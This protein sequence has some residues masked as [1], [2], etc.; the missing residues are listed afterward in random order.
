MFKNTSIKA[1]LTLVSL[2][3]AFA[4][5]A[6][7][8]VLWK[9]FSNIDLALVS[10]TKQELVFESL[11]DLRFHTVQIQQFLTDVGATHDSEGLEEAKKKS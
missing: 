7:V 3:L 5:L 11:K 10:A 4:S 6:Y 1:F 9:A 2:A 8:T